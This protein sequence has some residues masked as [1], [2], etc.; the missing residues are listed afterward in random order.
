MSVVGGGGAC[1]PRTRRLEVERRFGAAARGGGTRPR[2]I[3]AARREFGATARCVCVRGLTSVQFYLCFQVH[4][5]GRIATLDHCPADGRRAGGA[6]VLPSCYL[7]AC[8]NVLAMRSCSLLHISGSIRCIGIIAAWSQRKKL[9][10]DSSMCS[11]RACCTKRNA[12]RTT[13]LG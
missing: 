1:V 6:S 3:G 2:I 4:L 9:A 11:R 12:V 10:G 7:A 8:T 13:W 5:R